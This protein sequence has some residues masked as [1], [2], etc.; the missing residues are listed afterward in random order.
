MAEPEYFI[1]IGEEAIPLI[2]QY[3]IRGIM[4]RYSLNN[5][6]FNGRWDKII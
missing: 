5:D 3:K 4:N 6:Q 1:C 2:R